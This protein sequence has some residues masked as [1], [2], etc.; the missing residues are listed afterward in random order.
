[1]SND[2]RN[3]KISDLLYYILLLRQ[4]VTLKPLDID[5]LRRKLTS[6]SLSNVQGPS[7]VAS[8]DASAAIGLRYRCKEVVAGTGGNL[9]TLS[10]CIH[11]TQ[12][13]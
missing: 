5:A 2:V 6:T 11:P 13:E 9:D 3:E 4:P 12:L 1:L 10:A 7:S 8:V